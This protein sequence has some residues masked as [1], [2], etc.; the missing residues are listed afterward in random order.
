MNILR[1]FRD[2]GLRQKP[3]P[4]E[5]DGEQEYEIDAIAGHRLFRG[6]PDFMVS[7]VGYD[8]SKNMKLA[9]E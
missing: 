9:K 3:L 4:I 6:Q 2:N 5:V 7:F 1:V 8:A